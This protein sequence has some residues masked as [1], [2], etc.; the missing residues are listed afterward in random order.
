MASSHLVFFGTYT[1]STSRGIYAARLDDAT[2]AL[3]APTL[4]AETPSPTWVTLSPDKKFLYTVHGSKAQAVGFKVDA[5]NAKLIPLP[6]STDAKTPAP[7]PCHLVVDSTGRTLLAANYG[8]GYVEAI[9]IAADGTL[10][11]PNITQHTGRGPNPDRQEKPHVHCVAISPDNRYALVCDLGL[12]K[13]F[14]YRLDP[15]AAKLTPANPPFV[16]GAPGSGPRHLIFGPDGRRAY[17]VTEMG[18]TVVVY[19]YDP[20]GGTLTP[21]QTLSTL[22]PD[23]QAK[24]G[25]EI[26]IRPDGRFL[27]ASN[28]GQDTIAVFAID[29]A[30]G[31]LTLVEIVPTGGKVPRGFAISPDGGWIVCAHQFSDNV[32]VLK[33]DAETGRLTLTPNT[34]TVPMGVCVMFY[35]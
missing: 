8:D 31:R 14:S 28:R 25:A 16:A 2:G 29:P 12:D 34:I 9:P 13:I 10:G 21:I 17:N 27:Y 11:T 26:E 24:W 3:T 6:L 5:A 20:V 32:T 33:I 23:Y 30:T 4:A 1:R 19:D 35:D 18:A 7:G 22:P 15:A